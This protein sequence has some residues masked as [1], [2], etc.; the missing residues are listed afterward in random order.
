M[1]C[2]SS[3]V[4]TDLSGIAVFSELEAGSYPYSVSANGY[5][6]TE[7]GVSLTNSDITEWVNLTPLGMTQVS[8]DAISYRAYDL[9]GRAL[10]MGTMS[11]LVSA[12]PTR[13]VFLLV[14]GGKTIKV[15]K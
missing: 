9:S 3:D 4:S 11:E 15:V 12:L 1:T 7:G 2:N 6:L 10:G 8:A 14:G 5:V 13:G